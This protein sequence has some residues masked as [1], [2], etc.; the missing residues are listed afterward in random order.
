MA[1]NYTHKDFDHPPVETIDSFYDGLSKVW[2]PAMKADELNEGEAKSVKL[3]GREILVTKMDDNIVS[4][5]NFCPHFQAKLSD[6]TVERLCSTFERVVRCRYHG[7]AFNAKGECVEIPQLEDGQEIPKA[8]HLTT[9]KTQI[10][11]DLVWVC[12][13]GDPKTTIPMFPETETPD[14]VPTPIQYSEPWDGSMVRMMLSVLDDY[15]FPWLHEGILGTRDK[16]MPPKRNITWNGHELTSAFQSFQ[17]SNVTNA[18]NGDK[19]GSIVNYQMIVNMPN[20]I[21]LVKENDD[22]GK[23]VVH[24]YPHPISYDKTGLFWKVTRNYDTDLEGE[25]KILEMESFIQSQ[26][27]GHVG[28]QKPWLMPPTPVK[29]ADD[30]LVSYLQGLK[31]FGISPR[32]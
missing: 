29:G 22:G 31:E 2:L 17:P 1:K 30:A 3:L 25:K 13:D 18:V 15:H 19:D 14:M 5:P 6:G 27:R 4:M 11:H 9:Y 32:I 16:P 28:L 24:F 8:A 7:W 23:Y 10:G 20:I 21:R 12:L 26:D